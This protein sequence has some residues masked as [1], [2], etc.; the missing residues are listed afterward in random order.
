MLVF[1]R[2]LRFVLVHVDINLIKCHIKLS[3][4]L[5]EGRKVPSLVPLMWCPALSPLKSPLSRISAYLFQTRL[6]LSLTTVPTPKYLT[7]YQTH[8]WTGEYLGLGAFP[9]N[10][11]G[12]W[13]DQLELLSCAVADLPTVQQPGVKASEG[14]DWSAGALSTGTAALSSPIWTTSELWHMCHNY[15]RQKRKKNYKKKNNKRFVLSFL[16]CIAFSLES[17]YCVHSR[18]LA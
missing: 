2:N 11:L 10:L 12:V 9:L 14:L 7:F 4:L 8:G 1:Y 13:W 17:M 3:R 16:N 6:S 18:P 15:E 5:L